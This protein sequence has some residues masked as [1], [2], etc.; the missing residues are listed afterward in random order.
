MRSWVKSVSRR[1]FLTNTSRLSAAYAALHWLPLPAIA[2]SL[3]ADSRMAEKPV[4]DKGFASIRKI[5]DGVYATISDRTKGLQTRRMADSS[6]GVT[7]RYWS[8][9]SRRR[10]ALRFR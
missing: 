7:P 10:L 3:A 5:G 4:A 1:A 6:S 9:D 2:E 8:R